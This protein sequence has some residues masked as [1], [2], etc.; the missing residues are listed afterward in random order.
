M[1]SYH[2]KEHDEEGL[3]TLEAISNAHQFNRWM[4]EQVQ[5]Y[6][7]GRI[8]EVGSGI[9]N[10][11]KYFID[12]HVDI[13]LSD[14]RSAYCDELKRKFGNRKVHTLDLVHPNFV[15][16]YQ[17]L[18]GKF[19]SC[20][21]LNVIEHIEDDKL[22]LKNLVTLLKKGGKVAILVPAGPSL[23][24]DIDKGLYHFR[25]Y[26]TNSITQLFHSADLHINKKWMFNAL[27][28]PAWYFG[29][30]ILKKKEVE[31]EQMSLYNKLVPIA[32]VLDKLTFNKIGLSVI[33]L[34]AK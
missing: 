26:T 31:G 9:G 32:R 20:F 1:S 11:S 25:R 7:Q 5:P 34:G 24:N 10:I 18:L 8:L 16:E 13:E 21:A 14:V 28:I 29:G 6:M 19:D 2:F 3:N 27:G 4:F 17:D 22:A 15:N 30:K 12:A 23:Y 33:A